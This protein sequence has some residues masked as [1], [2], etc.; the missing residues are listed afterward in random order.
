MRREMVKKKNTY[1]SLL[2]LE[3]VGFFGFHD[4]KSE[5]VESVPCF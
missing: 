3:F 2:L 5:I 4:L 1:R